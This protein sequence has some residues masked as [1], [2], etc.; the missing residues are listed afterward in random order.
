MLETLNL[1]LLGLIA[2]MLWAL[3]SR[4][5][6]N[7]ARLARLDRL[8]EIRTAVKRMA[9]SGEG[10]DLRRLEHVLIDIRDGQKR[11]EER[12]VGLLE[13]TRLEA[14]Q[15]PETVASEGPDRLTAAG[16]IERLHA[17]LMAMGYERVQLL[18]SF[19]E[20]ASLV[21][22]GGEGELR[23]EARRD[24]VSCKGRVRVSGGVISAVELQASHAMFP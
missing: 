13:V 24:G 14:S 16:L 21:D 5:R 17:R 12:L 6:A 2:L 18:T 11:L 8:D 3:V 19:D 4:L 22:A 1:I 15:A 10:L 23:V 20:V 7:D 9:G